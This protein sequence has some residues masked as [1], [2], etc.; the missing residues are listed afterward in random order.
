MQTWCTHR[1]YHTGNTSTWSATFYGL[2]AALHEYL[3]ISEHRTFDPEE[4][5][6]TAWGLELAG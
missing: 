2:E 4:V 5:G 3:L 6:A 1:H